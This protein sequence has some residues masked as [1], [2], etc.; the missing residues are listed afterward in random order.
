MRIICVCVCIYVCA[1][2]ST[3]FLSLNWFIIKEF[4]YVIKYHVPEYVNP[5]SIIN[6]IQNK[7]RDY[8]MIMEMIMIISIMIMEKMRYALKNVASLK[9]FD[10]YWMFDF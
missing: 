5:V 4:D 3:N 1:F 10:S 2:L 7:N 6:R 8:G 9:P